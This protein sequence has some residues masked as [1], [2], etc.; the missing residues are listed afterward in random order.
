[1][2]RSRSKAT[3]MQIC[4]RPTRESLF[5]TIRTWRCSSSHVSR[6]HLDP[7]ML[8]GLTGSLVSHHFAQGVLHEEFAGCLGDAS[9]GAAQRSFARWWSSDGSRLGPASSARAVWDLAAAPVA[10]RLGFTVS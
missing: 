6:G 1:M 4:A 8:I 3:P 5:D 10:E 9:A 7:G 2:T